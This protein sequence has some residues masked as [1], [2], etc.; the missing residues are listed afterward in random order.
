MTDGP[1]ASSWSSKKNPDARK[2]HHHEVQ[3]CK[4]SDRARNAPRLREVEKQARGRR[5]SKAGRGNPRPLAMRP[6]HE[7][8]SLWDQLIRSNDTRRKDAA[9]DAMDPIAGLILCAALRPGRQSEGVCRRGSHWLCK[10]QP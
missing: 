6:T 1:W 7:R 9:S 5:D 3:A 4:R 8:A 10:T 2:R